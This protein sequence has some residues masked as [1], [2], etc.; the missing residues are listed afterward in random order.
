[1]FQGLRYRWGTP[2]SGCRTRSTTAIV[3]PGYGSFDRDFRSSNGRDKNLYENLE[4]LSDK[5]Q[6]KFVICNEEDYQWAR[7]KLDE[8][9]LR[10]KVGEILFSPSFEEVE[11]TDLANWIVRDRLLVRFQL[12]LHKILWGDKPGV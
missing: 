9:Q 11:A 7:F 3:R 12:Q 5:D 1:V 8:F 6:I 2:S 10:T 4:L